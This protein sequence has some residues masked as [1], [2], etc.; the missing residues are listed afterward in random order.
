MNLTEWYTYCFQNC[1]SD[2]EKSLGLMAEN[3]AKFL[4]SPK[5]FIQT[6]KSERSVPAI[7]ETE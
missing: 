1:S 7:F 5:Q 6:V 4:R 3:F 2:R